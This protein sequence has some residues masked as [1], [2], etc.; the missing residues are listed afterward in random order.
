MPPAAAISPSPRRAATCARPSC[1]RRNCFD[2]LVSVAGMASACYAFSAMYCSIDKIDLAAEVDG[3]PVALQTDHR[4]RDE[5][6]AEPELSAL[7]AMARIVNARAQLADDGHP[8]ADVHYVVSEDP[9]EHLR[10]ALIAAGGTI[11]RTDRDAALESLGPADEREV[12][13]IADRCMTTLA[14]RAAT[15]VGSR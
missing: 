11:E 15:R 7:F 6:E 14:R 8:S 5:I 2:R 10:E 3:K 4:S 9:P 12:G 1:A 13:E